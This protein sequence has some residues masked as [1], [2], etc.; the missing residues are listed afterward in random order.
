MKDRASEVRSL[1]AVL[2]EITTP[3]SYNFDNMGKYVDF[4][5]YYP[6]CDGFRAIIRK[7]ILVI[8]I[9]I[10]VIEVICNDGMGILDLNS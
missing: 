6:Y 8:P 4:F 9:T 10:R 7:N 2:A 5:A 1:D 3:L